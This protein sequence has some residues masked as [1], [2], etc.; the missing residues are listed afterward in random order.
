MVDPTVTEIPL[1]HTGH[2]A[3]ADTLSHDVG[4]RSSAPVAVRSQR[5]RPL[6]AKA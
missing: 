5:E 1:E 3:F 2:D 4:S 6:T